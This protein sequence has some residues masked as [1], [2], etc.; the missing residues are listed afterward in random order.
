[1]MF[2][3]T[4]YGWLIFRARSAAQV[5]EMTASLFAGFRPG[6]IDVDRLLVPLLLHITPFVVVH[7]AEAWHNDLLVVPRLSPGMRYSVYAATCY[8]TLLFGNF[9]GAEFIYFQF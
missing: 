9:G 3:L 4:C 5:G 8:L 7:A 1:V 2:H 6:T